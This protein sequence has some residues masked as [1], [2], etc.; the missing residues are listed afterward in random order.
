MDPKK[1]ETPKE[2]TIRML[3]EETEKFREHEKKWH[4]SKGRN[5]V[6]LGHKLRMAIPLGI[7]AIGIYSYTIHNFKNKIQ[8]TKNAIEE[9]KNAEG[10]AASN[11]HKLVPEPEQLATIEQRSFRPFAQE[12]GSGN[13]SNN[14]D[15][16]YLLDDV[17]K[18]W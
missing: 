16:E 3:K 7:L 1:E 12:S 15:G 14:D 8:R 6:P 13:N 2:R 4:E 9:A 10:I 11:L 5:N 17:N 18:K